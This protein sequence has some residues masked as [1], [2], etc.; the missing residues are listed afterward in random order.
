[1]RDLH[2]HV[3]QRLFGAGLE[4]QVIAGANK[5]DAERARISEQV[6][7]LDSAIA[8]IRTAIF[9]MKTESPSDG[10]SIRH[11]IVGLLGE[12][13]WLA[14]NSPALRFSGPLD[15]LVP[16]EMADDLLAVIR[17]GLANVAKHAQATR[18]S[19]DVTAVDG[20]LTV[21]IEDNGNGF[22]PATVVRSSGTMNLAERAHARG[23]E[24]TLSSS[25]S[26]GT[27]LVW[28]VPLSAEAVT[29]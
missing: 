12:S 21:Q 26:A 9:A 17:E 7:A 6:E 24:F 2:D 15:L 19:V 22:D 10:S 20:R 3:I 13:T 18:T 23:G 29:S 1:A 11:R 25:P 27:V 8:E 5:N 28:S 16:A 4:L 14:G